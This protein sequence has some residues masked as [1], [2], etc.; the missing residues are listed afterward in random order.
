MAQ[1]AVAGPWRSQ[2]NTSAPTTPGVASDTYVLT[3]TL[4]TNSNVET[5]VIFTSK[6][7]PAMMPRSLSMSNTLASTVRSE[8][9]SRVENQTNPIALYSVDRAARRSR[10]S[11]SL[12]S[13]ESRLV[14]VRRQNAVDEV[15]HG[16]RRVDRRRV[17]RQGRSR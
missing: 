13:G 11:I 14:I 6:I 4:A 5:T 9:N 16:L 10:S 12:S 3:V 17:T 15:E 1:V 7:L 2:H 8:P